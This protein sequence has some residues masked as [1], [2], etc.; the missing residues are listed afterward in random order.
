MADADHTL[1]LMDF[2]AAHCSDQQ[3]TTSHEQYRA[4]VYFH[5]AQAAAMAALERSGPESAIEELDAGLA[6]L[7]QVFA[8]IQAGEEF[9]QDELVAQLV[10]LKESLRKE[11]QFGPTLAEQLSEAVAGEEY[12]RAARLRDEIARRHDKPAVCQRVL[13]AWPFSPLG[14]RRTTR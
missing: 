10:E 8:S 5:R 6:K 1:A 4:F 14:P 3:W 13:P 7:R 2:V 11:Y 9:Q 12:E